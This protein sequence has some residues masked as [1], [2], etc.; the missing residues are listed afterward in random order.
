MKTERLEIRITPELK[1]QIQALAA[2][3]WLDEETKVRHTP[4]ISVDEQEEVLKRLSSESLDRMS[5]TP[6]DKNASPRSPVD[7]GGEE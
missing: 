2:A 1:S 4:F 7:T 5:G 6:S 3:D